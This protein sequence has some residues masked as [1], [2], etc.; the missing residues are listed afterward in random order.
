[1]KGREDRALAW[2]ERTQGTPSPWRT[3]HCLGNLDNLVIRLDFS[4]TRQ[5]GSAVAGA[6]EDHVLHA[7]RRAVCA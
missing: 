2:M 6:T 1:M 7:Q 5:R 4:K 3:A